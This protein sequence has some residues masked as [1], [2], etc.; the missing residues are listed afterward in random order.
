M[1]NTINNTS[2]TDIPEYTV[3][4]II[5]TI[6]TNQDK[7]A[8]SNY[9]NLSALIS[10]ALYTQNNYPSAYCS[11]V[12]IKSMETAFLNSIDPVRIRNF[13]FSEDVKS[14]DM[15]TFMFN[16]Q[17]Y[18]TVL[19]SCYKDY[20]LIDRY[21]NNRNQFNNF[22]VINFIGNTEI[23]CCTDYQVQTDTGYIC[24]NAKI[25][26]QL[27]INEL[28][29]DIEELNITHDIMDIA[30]QSKLKIMISS[31]IYITL[32]QLGAET[33]YTTQERLDIIK[34]I[35]SAILCYGSI[36]VEFITTNSEFV[37]GAFGG[38]G[39]INNVR[40]LIN[41]SIVGWKTISGELYWNVRIPEKKQTNYI[42]KE[43]N[44]FIKSS[45]HLA[46]ANWTGID[47]PIPNTIINGHKISGPYIIKVKTTNI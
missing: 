17:N 25:A 19:S 20:K 14:S 5:L 29:K 2:I 47:I 30:N 39:V 31:F 32:T 3:P 41:A 13:I 21:Y 7:F 35:Q 28:L 26:K 24:N 1:G 42:K 11:Y 40:Y 34:Q 45:I 16:N 43:K 18:Y 33:F 6:K 38:V 37:V 44:E 15:A 36:G 22:A 4:G 9:L 10:D 23:P 8:T 27:K 46:T 12:Y